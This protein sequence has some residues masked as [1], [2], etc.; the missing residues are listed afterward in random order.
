MKFKGTVMTIMNIDQDKLPGVSRDS[1]N[2]RLGILFQNMKG[3]KVEGK[4]IKDMSA[5][6]VV[7]FVI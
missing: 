2:T 4:C 5:K 1:E 3:F 6:V 7:L